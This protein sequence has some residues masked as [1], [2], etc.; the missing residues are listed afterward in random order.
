M[1]LL[2]GEGDK[3]FLRLQEEILKVSP[4]ET[5]FAW[6][7]EGV[8]RYTGALAPSP[9]VFVKTA[10]VARAWELKRRMTPFSR[11]N[12]G[13]QR[14]IPLIPA[15]VSA[16]TA[17]CVEDDLVLVVGVLQ[18]RVDFDSEDYIG[19]LLSKKKGGDWAWRWHN[20][21]LGIQGLRTVPVKAAKKA[22][23]EDI[24]GYVYE[25][26]LLMMSSFRGANSRPGIGLAYSTVTYYH[27]FGI[28]TIVPRSI[29]SLI[30]Y[31]CSVFYLLSGWILAASVSTHFLSLQSTILHRSATSTSLP[32]PPLPFPRSFLVAPQSG[33]VLPTN[34]DLTHAPQHKNV[35]E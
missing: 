26:E 3:A 28:Q 31:P 7:Q 30:S 34:T 20:Q 23:I 17:S 11:T 9:A 33:S 16:E 1:P 10:G 4:N 8:P 18:C 27:H 5:L 25:R 24:R 12:R 6:H 2:Y 22:V 29:A 32:K 15:S 21:D 13:V 14:E 35:Q 19:I